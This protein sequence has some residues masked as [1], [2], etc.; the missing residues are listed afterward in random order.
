MTHRTPANL[1]PE[2]ANSLKLLHKNAQIAQD[3]RSVFIG[4]MANHRNLGSG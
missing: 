4:E 3:K 1:N 2:I